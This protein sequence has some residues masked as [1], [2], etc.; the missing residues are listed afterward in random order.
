[1]A[2]RACGESYFSVCLKTTSDLKFRAGIEFGELFENNLDCSIKCGFDYG[3][4]SRVVRSQR[5]NDR[6]GRLT[7]CDRMVSERMFEASH[8]CLTIPDRCILSS[9]SPC[10]S[11]RASRPIASASARSSS[12][13]RASPKRSC[14]GRSEERRVGKEC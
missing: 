10:R 7:R 13:P 2:K 9:A 5:G 4:I 11:A 6:Q 8:Q 12:P 1:M 3:E 14:A